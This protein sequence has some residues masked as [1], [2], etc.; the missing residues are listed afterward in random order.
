[1]YEHIEKVIR[2]A[3][4]QENRC[5]PKFYVIGGSDIYGFKS[6]K[7]S[8]FDVRG[9]HVAPAA[10]FLKLDPPKEQIIINQGGVT[11]GYEAFADVDLESFELRKFG[12]LVRVMNFNTLE[13][14]F[15]GIPLI[16]GERASMDLLREEIVKHMPGDVP[17]HYMGMAKMNYHKYLAGTNLHKLEAKK[18]LYVLRG[19]LAARFVMKYKDIQPNIRIMATCLLD[20][21]DV[22][23]I[24]ELI[25][26]KKY[27]EDGKVD[28]KLHKA[29]MK[30][31]MRLLE[32]VNA[33]KTGTTIPAPFLNDW[34]LGIR[35]RMS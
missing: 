2:K 10:E 14:L 25:Y 17:Y 4:A 5:Y 15:A 9:F 18:Y 30:L 34:M 7:G 6:D 21:K 8:D 35:E 28:D 1:M 24:E 22:C 16:N 26:V 33:K 31:I 27:A 20:N 32:G 11:Q 3:V 13:Q 19:A 12:Q 29:S 23:T